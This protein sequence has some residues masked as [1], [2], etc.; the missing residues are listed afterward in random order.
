MMTSLVISARLSQFVRTDAF[1]LWTEIIGRPVLTNGERLKS[2]IL[3]E[4]AVCDFLQRRSSNMKTRD[5]WI[6]DP[7]GTKQVLSTSV[8]L[9]W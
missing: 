6:V 2:T 1:N 4:S 5:P 7:K 3:L 8:S 9:S